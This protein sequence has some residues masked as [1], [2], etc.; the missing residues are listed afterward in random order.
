MTCPFLTLGTRG[1]S[2]DRGGEFGALFSPLSIT[3]L[4]IERKDL[5]RDGRMEQLLP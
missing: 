5:G 4:E 3:A 2:T 1:G